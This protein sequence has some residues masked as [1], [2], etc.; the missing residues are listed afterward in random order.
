MHYHASLIGI[1]RNWGP[2]DTKNHSNG[3]AKPK[4]LSH[5]LQPG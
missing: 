4:D 3:S 5:I 2:G 1:R